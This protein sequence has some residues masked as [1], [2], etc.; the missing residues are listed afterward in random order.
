MAGAFEDGLQK[1]S[2]PDPRRDGK[3]GGQKEQKFEHLRVDFSLKSLTFKRKRYLHHQIQD[4]NF[5][6]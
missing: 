4:I 6:R 5:R 3:N 1:N 2:W